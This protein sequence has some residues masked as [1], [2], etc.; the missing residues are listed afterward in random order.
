[1]AKIGFEF[2]PTS[3][4]TEQRQDF[5]DLPNGIYKLE[6]VASAVIESDDKKKV[7]AKTTFNVIEPEEFKDRKVFGYYNLRNPSAQAEKIGNDQFASLCRAAGL[8]QT[9][10][11]TEDLHFHSFIAKVGMGKANNGY[12]AKNEI[13]KYFF[14]DDGPGGHEGNMPEPEI[15][16]HQPDPA[17][18]PAND[19]KPAPR[20]AAAAS[21]GDKPKRPWGK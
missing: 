19:N 20:Q 11:D 16:A 8:S 17:P 4:D 21:G 2:D 7:G 1:M 18:K 3:H 6:T 9:V 10:D 12:P 13:K 15:D 5:D 14:N